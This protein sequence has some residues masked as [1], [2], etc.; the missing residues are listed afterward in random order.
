MLLNLVAIKL[1]N[2][3]LKDN[4][5]SRAHLAKYAG[6]SFKLI[7]PGFSINALFDID[8]YLIIN[9]L[10]S[11]EVIIN[12]P[13]DSVT[14]LI[15]KDK[16]AVYKK[17]SFVGNKK[18]GHELLENF[19]KLHVDGIYTKIHSP[20]ML[21]A[22][23]KFTDLIKFISAY[24]KRLPADSGNTLKEYLMYETQ[25]IITRYEN[26]S[27]CND[28]DEIKNRYEYL[29]QQIKQ[30][31]QPATSGKQRTMHKIGASI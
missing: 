31:K 23:N 26:D 7:L 8:G 17:I 5:G 12:I 25:D 9:H 6:K 28:V 2:F 22:L 3:I 19:S 20:I 18:F 11:Y 14:F 15:D 4:H 1:I 24:L 16:L 10:T 27:F 21:I 29:E 30:F 13:L